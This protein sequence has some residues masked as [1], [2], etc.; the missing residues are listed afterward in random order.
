LSDK[1]GIVLI[2]EDDAKIIELIS[3]QIRD[4]GYGIDT[5]ADGET[6]LQKALENDYVLLVLDLMLPGLGGLEVCRRIR[7]EKEAL[8]ILMLTACTGDVETVLGLE[9]GADEYMTKPFRVLEFRA[10]VRALLRRVEA[11][12]KKHGA[13]ES[14]ETI[15]LHGLTIDLDRRQVSLN[16]DQVSLTATQ[17]H[18]LALLASQ[19]GRVFTREELISSARGYDCDVYEHNVNSHISRLRGK[20]EPDPVNPTFIKTVRGMGYRFAEENEFDSES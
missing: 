10:R 15:S 12:E 13:Y 16:G 6:G 14:Q 17:Y 7:A 2:V 18:L 8:P 5:A 20:I 11:I 3:H 4:L 9:L 1:T 19:P